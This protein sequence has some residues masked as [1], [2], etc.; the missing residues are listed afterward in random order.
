M[1]KKLDAIE[2]NT[3]FLSCG[4]S[5][6][7]ALWK[8]DDVSSFST[9]T[10]LGSGRWAGWALANG[11]TYM[12]CDAKEVISPNLLNRF[13]VG[14]GNGSDYTLGVT[15]GANEVTLT[16]AQMPA[17]NHAVTDPGHTHTVTDPGHTHA[18]TQDPH[19]HVA[20]QGAHNHSV[21]LTTSNN[22]SHNHETGFSI[23]SESGTGLNVRND[24][25]SGVATSDNGAHT[26]SVTG[27]TDNSTPAVSVT[28]ASVNISVTEAQT[29]ITL[30]SQT[31]GISTVNKG[32][33]EAHENRPPY[34]AVIYVFKL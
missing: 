21:D 14:G 30:E 32:D 4:S 26:H 7:I 33:G 3:N 12:G 34:Y 28:E 17:H 13:L 22:G 15:G 6:L 25:T 31:T 29:G 18:T 1:K 9:S 11:E 23:I 8:A 10:G 2:Y 16:E 24:G 27:N 5:P 19:T 20:S